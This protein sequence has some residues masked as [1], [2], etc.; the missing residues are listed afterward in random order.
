[1]TCW[2]CNWLTPWSGVLLKKL[3]IN[4]GEEILLHWSP[5]VNWSAHK[6][7]APDRNLQHMN[8][9]HTLTYLFTI[10]VDRHVNLPFIHRSSEWSLSLKIFRLKY[11]ERWH[12]S[13][14][15][16]A[17]RSLL[18]SASFIWR[19]V[20]VVEALRIQF[21]PFYCYFLLSSDWSYCRRH[22]V[23]NSIVFFILPWRLMSNSDTY[24]TTGKISFLS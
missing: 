8:P 23:L 21:S 5:R 6:W 13:S 14:A 17:S 11:N 24:K 15:K 10:V 18:M 19:T 9:S 22:F 7:S 2:F 20:Q 16:L 1:M 4:A 3:V 12:L